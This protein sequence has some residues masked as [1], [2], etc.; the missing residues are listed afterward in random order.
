MRAPV[1]ASDYIVSVL[2]ANRASDL[3]TSTS[4]LHNYPPT[5]PSPVA[6]SP[7]TTLAPL[8]ITVV[9]HGITTDKCEHFQTSF[10]ATPLGIT[11]PFT[12]AAY[13]TERLTTCRTTPLPRMRADRTC[14]FTPQK[15]DRCCCLK[16][17]RRARKLAALQTT[18]GITRSEPTAPG[19]M[20]TSTQ[21]SW[22]WSCSTTR[23]TGY[24]FETFSTSVHRRKLQH[25]VQ[26]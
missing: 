1:S 19:T 9:P 5:F 10:L 21:I 16:D 26:S 13:P 4:C 14:R 11:T 22:R 3:P 25:V 20:N 18:L 17:P 15:K 23:H 2:R 7:T 6:H 8:V 24:V 12:S